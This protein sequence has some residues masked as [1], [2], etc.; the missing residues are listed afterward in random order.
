LLR[1]EGPDI[2][3]APQAG[4]PGLVGLPV[5]LWTTRTPRTWGPV[6]ATASVPGLSVTATAR[7][8]RIVWSMGD[9]HSVTCTRPGTP[10]RESLGGRRSPDC[11]YVYTQP[12]TT[13]PDGTY[14]VTGTTTWRVV[15][16]GGGDSGA[17]TLTRS[18]TTT[19]E[20]GELQVLIS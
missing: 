2:G 9:G 4:R 15:W 10:Y 12:S 6:S 11:G 17:I 3:R 8:Q 19:V 7:A 1:L 13:E 16:A 5:W 18:S 20:I 14:R